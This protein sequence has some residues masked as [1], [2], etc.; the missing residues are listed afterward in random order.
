M[1]IVH[2]LRAPTGGLFRHVVDLANGQVARGH[3]V[4]LILDSRTLMPRSRELLAAVGPQLELGVSAIPMSR[5][6]SP[7]DLL[8][9]R[10]VGFRL[11]QIGPEIVHGHGAKGGAYAR[12]ANAPTAKVRAYTPHG[13]SLHDSA[14]SAL[15]N[16]IERMLVGS[17]NLYLFE[18][19]FA[20][21][22][23]H[24]KI[25]RPRG[26]SQVVHNGLNAPDFEPVALA[27]N[28]TDLLFLGELRHLKGIDVLIDAV[29]ILHS[30]H[31]HITA[32]IVGDGR[33]LAQLRGRVSE[34]NLSHAIHFHAGMSARTAF[35]LGRI[36]V[37]PS[38]AESLP[39]V[40]LEAAAAGKPVIST[41]VGGISEI[42]G[43]LA[44]ELV[45]P[46]NAAILAEKIA[47]AI[48]APAK[49]QEQVQR[50]RA[51]TASSFTADS[52]VEGVLSAYEQA[53]AMQPEYDYPVAPILA[54]E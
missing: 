29:A 7:A 5:Q 11:R 45:P 44:D 36:V 18:S 35:Q 6:P 48:D 52:M 24:R 39:Y 50:L 15:H 40:V 13:G 21:N 16:V 49:T 27:T 33:D 14:A 51:R 3:R 9:V 25:G 42:F 23:F 30:R 31:R 2:V 54:H 38:R 32:S 47:Q 26:L 43:D 10:R 20:Q 8:T 37:V 1:K 17:G 53:L 19:D 46:G 4:G 28:A 41:R 22:A 12:L 34:L